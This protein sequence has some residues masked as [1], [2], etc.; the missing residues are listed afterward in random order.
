MRDDTRTR[1]IL[2]ISKP[3][4][5]PEEQTTIH[6]HAP[7]RLTFAIPRRHVPH[8]VRELSKGDCGCSYHTKM[9]HAAGLVF[10]IQKDPVSQQWL[11]WKKRKE[12]A[13]LKL[14]DLIPICLA[15]TVS[16]HELT[17]W[18]SL[19][20]LNRRELEWTIPLQTK[21]DDTVGVR[22]DRY[23]A[24]CIPLEKMI[25]KFPALK[26]G[27]GCRVIHLGRHGIKISW[28]PT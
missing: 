25:T 19:A 10:V 23:E 6:A 24:I 8:V 21:E 3:S 13:V 27:K 1:Q 14:R 4:A 11:R 22:P 12:E 28:K 2:P 18:L 7:P 20:F 26:S 5:W 17:K 16:D 9:T 15:G